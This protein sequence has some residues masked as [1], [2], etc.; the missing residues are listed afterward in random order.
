[1]IKNNCAN[2]GA[3]EG[4]HH[5][6]TNQCPVGGREAP[7]NQ[8]QE[9]METTFVEAPNIYK[10]PVTYTFKGTVT[11]RGA[12]NVEQAEEWAGQLVGST[13]KIHSSLRDIDV[14]WEFP[15]HP[16]TKVSKAQRI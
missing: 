10:V 7:M 8:R 5:Y 16:D 14:D 9:Y 3:P 1:M 2:C 11:I 4:L 15:M 6:K 12:K 13:I